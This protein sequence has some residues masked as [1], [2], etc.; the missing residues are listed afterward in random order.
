[1][2]HRTHRYHTEFP[3]EMRT[4]LGVLQ[5]KIADVNNDGAR[6]EH[7]RR[8][9]RG[10]KIAFSVLGRP[11]NAIVIWSTHDQ[12]GIVF[13]PRLHDEI[14]DMIRYRRDGPKAPHRCTVGFVEMR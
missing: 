1:M 12:I 13:R 9:H 5:G 7:V 8:M 6:I 14:V 2:Q 3:V 4:P 11:V 10:S